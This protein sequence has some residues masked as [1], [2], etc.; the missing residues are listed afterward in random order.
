MAKKRGR[1][2]HANGMTMA[3]SQGAEEDVDEWEDA[4]DGSEG[5]AVEPVDEPAVV[6]EAA[7]AVVAEDVAVPPAAKATPVVVVA[8]AAPPP[9]QSPAAPVV[10]TSA[11]KRLAFVQ[12]AL[13]A[14]STQY[15]T[16]RASVPAGTKLMKS[17]EFA[18]GLTS[19]VVPE[20]GVDRLVC[21]ADGVVDRAILRT[22]RTLEAAKS[23]KH[24][25]P[26]LDRAAPFVETALTVAT[27]FAEQP[28]AETLAYRNMV[29]SS[30]NDRAQPY[31]S[32]AT[33]LVEP[34]VER[35]QVLARPV[36]E[37]LAPR[38]K[39]LVDPL[40]TELRRL[41]EAPVA[42]ACRYRD[43][44]LAYALATAE[45][46]V[47][48]VKGQPYYRRTLEAAEPYY[49]RAREVAIEPVLR[50]RAVSADHLDRLG[51][52]ARGVYAGAYERYAEP[53]L[54]MV[55]ARKPLGELAAPL[56]ESTASKRCAE[57]Y[58]RAWVTAS[59]YV[60]KAMVAA[61]PVLDRVTPVA[62]SLAR[63]ALKVV[64]MLEDDEASD[65]A[66]ARVVD[67]LNALLA[68]FPTPERVL[69]MTKAS[70][71]VPAH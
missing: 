61:D 9:P 18:E 4:V 40:V 50:V 17:L 32:R 46:L 42:G 34:L 15:A 20:K 43:A 47:E 11:V 41:Y 25:G 31:V 14:V 58:S 8:A 59:P 51:A 6:E 39:P 57:A 70:V 7:P 2:G 21:L 44:A 23:Q 62:S 66:L 10:T 68:Y 64:L 16:Y 55:Q 69:T 37:Q 56:L 49:R 19:R 27:K 71:A 3:V 54:R 12:S 13:Q 35:A 63:T 24:L 1:V 53:T 36:T 28:V 67:R 52:Q 48:G 26:M 22:E 33:E 65:K 45:P 30:A 60:E 5:V 29:L 38:V